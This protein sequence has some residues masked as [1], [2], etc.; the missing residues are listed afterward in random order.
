MHAQTVSGFRHFLIFCGPT[1]K[2]RIMS[3][4]NKRQCQC[5]NVPPL[6]MCC[7]GRGLPAS[8]QHRISV[9]I[10]RKKFSCCGRHVHIK[11]AHITSSR[12]R[13]HSV[14][15]IVIFGEKIFL[16]TFLQKNPK[17]LEIP[18]YIIVK[19]IMY[20]KNLKTEF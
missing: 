20:E 6:R 4:L 10:F 11:K 2:L 9:T 14:P 5:S 17:I 1:Q 13:S 16:K 19:E 12:G 8:S 15:R 7:D 3:L 18:L